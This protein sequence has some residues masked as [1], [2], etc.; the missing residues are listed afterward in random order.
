[1]TFFSNKLVGTWDWLLTTKWS[2]S[3]YTPLVL[4]ILAFRLVKAKGLY[5]FKDL[6]ITRMLCHARSMQGMG[7]CKAKNSSRKFSSWPA[8]S[9]FQQFWVPPISLEYIMEVK[10][11][12]WEL[13]STAITIGPC[14]RKVLS[15]S[16]YSKGRP[17]DVLAQDPVSVPSTHRV[18]SPT[19]T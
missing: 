13:W 19:E 18:A 12:F 14:V 17:V 7:I 1:M 4:A 9:N 11:F 2:E 3:C 8:I 16:N 10:L 15:W 5:I 6:N